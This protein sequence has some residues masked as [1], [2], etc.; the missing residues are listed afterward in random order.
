MMFFERN[1]NKTIALQVNDNVK[2]GSHVIGKHI[3]Y[4]LPMSNL[5][6]DIR[7]LKRIV[8]EVDLHIFFLLLVWFSLESDIR[9]LGDMIVGA[10]P[11]AP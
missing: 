8:K 11:H 4:N 6:S 1:K 3:I 9:N 10:S 5:F 2:Y 7:K